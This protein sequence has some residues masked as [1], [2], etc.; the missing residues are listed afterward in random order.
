MATTAP[1]S[2]F[3][4]IMIV[5]FWTLYF[6]VFLRTII[7]IFMN[8]KYTCVYWRSALLDKDALLYY[9]SADAHMLDV[10]NTR[11]LFWR[12][13]CIWFRLVKSA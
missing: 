13:F 9:N 12:I 5:F 10:Q 6:I 3:F 7:T 4:I 1:S 11:F 8:V 2:S